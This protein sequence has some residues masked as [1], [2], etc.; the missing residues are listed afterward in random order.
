METPM[1]PVQVLPRWLSGVVGGLPAGVAAA[2]W[3]VIGVIGGPPRIFGMTPKDSELVVGL[4]ALLI[5]LVI[6]L[7]IL[8]V[9]QARALK[10]LSRRG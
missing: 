6:S 9:A 5:G 4:G 1:P 8:C 10:A 2:S 7:L 3:I